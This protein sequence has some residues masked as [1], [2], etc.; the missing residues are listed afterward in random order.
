MTSTRASK[1]PSSK[2]RTQNWELLPEYEEYLRKVSE[3]YKEVT[4]APGMLW[5]DVIVMR[6]VTRAAWSTFISN[7]GV[8]DAYAASIRPC[9]GRPRERGAK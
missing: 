3:I 7:T 5:R 9:K 6:E 1:A 4:E 2:H 8:S